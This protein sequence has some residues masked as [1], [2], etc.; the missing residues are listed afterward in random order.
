M[1]A[2]GY[3]PPN[4]DAKLFIKDYQ[5]LVESLSN[6]KNKNGHIIIGIDH[7]MDLLKYQTHKLTQV[8]LD[9]NYDKNMYPTISRPTRIT[10]TSATL[11]DNIF[12]SENLLDSHKSGIL[13]ND[14][15]DHLPCLL[16][17]Q[18]IDHDTKGPNMTLS[19]DLNDTKLTN[20]KNDLLKINW[21]EVLNHDN[22]QDNYNNLRPN[23]DK[24]IEYTRTP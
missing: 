12:I 10:K 24:R 16:T 13:V 7:N 17:V 3:R 18:N 21:H 11:I 15:S 14:M 8:F 6:G 20:I 1:L 5:Q 22:C 9:S 19:R 23:V 2:S 4:V